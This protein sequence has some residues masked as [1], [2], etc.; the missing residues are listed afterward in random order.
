M[1]FTEEQ[2]DTEPGKKVHVPGGEDTVPLLLVAPAA[3]AQLEQPVPVTSKAG[4]VSIKSP[5][6][7]TPSP[8]LHDVIVPVESV[9]T[10]MP[11]S[12]GGAPPDGR[13][14]NKVLVPLTVEKPSEKLQDAGTT[15]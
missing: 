14:V 15:L 4:D 2:V 11:L 13:S 5:G 8:T 10:Y 3:P 7:W 9:E 1:K 6:G 12:Y